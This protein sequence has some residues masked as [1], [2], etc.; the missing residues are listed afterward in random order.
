MAQEK[1]ARKVR[2]FRVWKIILKLIKL[3]S[4]KI[5]RNGEQNVVHIKTITHLTSVLKSEILIEILIN[6]SRIRL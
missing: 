3:S 4:S 5:E 1:F 2:L 6:L